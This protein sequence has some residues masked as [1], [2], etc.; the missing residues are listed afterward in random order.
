MLSSSG[1]KH[2]LLWGLLKSI[3][4]PCWESH[5]TTLCKMYVS[6]FIFHFPNIPPTK[7]IAVWNWINSNVWCYH[8]KSHEHRVLLFRDVF[9]N[10]WTI[11]PRHKV[12]SPNLRTH[13]SLVISH[14]CLSL[15]ISLSLGKGRF[16]SHQLPQST[17]V[18]YMSFTYTT[19]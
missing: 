15:W 3:F 14:L 12:R 16:W 10:K 9:P 6:K 1:G 19:V 17:F 7:G 13:R 5:T 8:W 2:Q 4:P 11:T 18:K